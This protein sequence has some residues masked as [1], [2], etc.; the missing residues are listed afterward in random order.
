MNT[1]HAI[2][3]IHASPRRR[4]PTST[5][6]AKSASMAH[7]VEQTSGGDSRTSSGCRAYQPARL[8]PPGFSRQTAFNDTS[9]SPLSE[10]QAGRLRGM[11]TASNLFNDSGNHIGPAP[12]PA[13]ARESAEA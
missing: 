2:S 10:R 7:T 8:A 9:A 3:T 12:M 11:G 13:S 6:R 5:A 4:L 1:S